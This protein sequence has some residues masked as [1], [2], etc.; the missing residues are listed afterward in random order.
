MS[1]EAGVSKTE[2]DCLMKMMSS[3]EADELCEMRAFGRERPLM[4]V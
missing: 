2:F 4:S 3:A 1:Q